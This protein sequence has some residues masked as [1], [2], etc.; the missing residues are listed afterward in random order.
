VQTIA[1]KMT[2]LQA[3]MVPEPTPD[4]NAPARK[5]GPRQNDYFDAVKEVLKAEGGGLLDHEIATLVKATHPELE[6]PANV[7]AHL[8]ARVAKGYLALVGARKFALAA[9]VAVAV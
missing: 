2:T 4:P 1:Q 5:R 3:G 7:Y 9:P 6:E 8:Y